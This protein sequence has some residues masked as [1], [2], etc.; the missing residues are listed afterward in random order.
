MFD[1]VLNIPL[2]IPGK[3]PVVIPTF[4]I[5]RDVQLKAMLN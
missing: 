2:K 5:S 1:M 4:K 3:E